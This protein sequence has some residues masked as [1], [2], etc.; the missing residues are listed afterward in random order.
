MDNTFRY[1]NHISKCIKRSYASLKLIYPHRRYLPTDVK[2]ML[3]S[4]LVL[5]QFCYL[6]QVYA[7]CLTVRDKT[8]IQRVQNSCLRL[9]YGVRKY[10]RI[11]HKRKEAGWLSMDDRFLL[12]SA[13]LYHKIIITKTPHYL[14]DRIRFRTD[15]HNLNVRFKS[16]ITPPTHKT[17]LFER[18]FSFCI[19]KTYNNIPSEI[20]LKGLGGFKKAMIDLLKEHD[21]I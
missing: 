9:A 11:S 12:A 16:Q 15:V 4:A 13:C 8:R 7:P 1:S 10:Q 19:Y 17:T 3:C 18:S 5:S 21:D 2:L 20:K 6:S 14:Y